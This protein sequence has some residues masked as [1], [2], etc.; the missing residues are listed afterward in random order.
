MVKTETLE[1]VIDGAVTYH[2]DVVS[3][4][5]YLCRVGELETP[6][7]GDELDDGMLELRSEA[8]D[9]LLGV[10]VIS[11][12]KRFGTGPLPD[13]IAEIEARIAPLAE[14]VMAAVPA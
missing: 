8:D 7:I 13:S 11:W 2:L 6:K 9:E 3:D 12:W 10:T 1:G 5:L 4:V 14:R